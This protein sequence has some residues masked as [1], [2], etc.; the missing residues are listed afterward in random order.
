MKKEKNGID[1]EISPSTIRQRVETN[2]RY[3]HHVAEG[4]ISPLLRLELTVVQIILKMPRIL[5][6]LTPSQGLQLVNR[7]IKGTK[8]QEEVIAWK[9]RGYSNNEEV[10]IGRG[11]WGKFMKQNRDKIFIKRGQKYK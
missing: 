7:L 9:K 6:C 2:S 5:Q 10:V 3:S 11:Y 1:T 8:L 4:Q